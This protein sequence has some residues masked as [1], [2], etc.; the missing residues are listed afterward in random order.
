MENKTQV[1]RAYYPSG[2]LKAEWTYANGRLDGT[3]TFYS[4]KGKL[5]AT[6][7]YKD[8]KRLSMVV[9]YL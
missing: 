2:A 4:E 7:T 5:W 9:E 3:C 6:E 1:K 8:G